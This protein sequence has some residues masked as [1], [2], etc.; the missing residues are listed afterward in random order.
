MYTHAYYHIDMYLHR[1]RGSDSTLNPC[2]WDE[3][4]EVLITKWGYS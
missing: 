4:G 3:R 1:E 2:R